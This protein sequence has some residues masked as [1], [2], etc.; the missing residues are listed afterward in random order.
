MVNNDDDYAK[1]LAEKTRLTLTDTWSDILCNVS[2]GAAGWRVP[3]IIGP[4]EKLLTYKAGALQ[5][6]KTIRN[7]M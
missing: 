4:I 5:R 6:I 3:L 7:V 1:S 2:S